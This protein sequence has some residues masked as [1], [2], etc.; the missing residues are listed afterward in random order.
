[1][2]NTTLRDVFFFIVILLS[3]FALDNDSII[4]WL[5]SMIA[6]ILAIAIDMQNNN[7]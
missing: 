4:C 2:K 5:F 6:T 1:M 7:K 3:Y